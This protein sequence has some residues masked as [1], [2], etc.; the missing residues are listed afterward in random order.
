MLI[1]GVGN[2]FRR[3]DGAGPAAAAMVKAK[4][5]S[6]VRVLVRTGEGADLIECW[7]LDDNVIVVDAMK[8][9]GEPGTVIRID[10]LA[11]GLPAGHF[12]VSSH[13][14]G[15]GD[16]VE[17][18]RSLGRLPRALAVYGIEAGD[19]GDGEGLS[20]EVARGVEQAAG[21]ILKEI[22]K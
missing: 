22:T 18:A 8:S 13:S 5:G 21:M 9:G 17:V 10:A 4:A 15:V 20:P 14:F 11:G 6:G 1:I 7:G 12:A 2:P 3:D 19:T 16:A